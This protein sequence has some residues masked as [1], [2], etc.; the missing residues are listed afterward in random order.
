MLNFDA[1]NSSVY[2]KLIEIIKMGQF[3]LGSVDFDSV[4]KWNKDY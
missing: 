1:Y 4:A 3:I 2:V